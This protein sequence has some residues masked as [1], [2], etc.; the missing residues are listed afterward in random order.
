[1]VLR[2]AAPLRSEAPLRQRPGKTATTSPGQ[3]IVFRRGGH[4]L[5]VFPELMAV[6]TRKRSVQEWAARCVE[7]G[8]DG[9]AF[10]PVAQVK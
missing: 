3:E 4:E 6:A 2:R 5:R 7:M 8:I 1:M 10:A 9:L